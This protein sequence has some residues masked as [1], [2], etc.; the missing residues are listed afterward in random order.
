MNVLDRAVPALRKAIRTVWAVLW[1]AVKKYDE[2]DAEQRAASFAYYAFFALF[3]LIVLLISV[4]TT[5]LGSKER[6]TTEITRYVSHYMPTIEEDDSSRIVGTIDGVVKS[7]Q[8]AGLIAFGILA[9]TAM[10]FFHALVRGVNRAWGT[11]EY[12]WWRLPI[13]N[14][15]MTA[16]LAS[17]LLVGILAPLVV[18]QVET[19]YWAHS[20]ELGLNFWFAENFFN[21]LRFLV[22]PLVLFYGFFMLYKVSPRRKTTFR[23]V[24]FSALFV[25]VGVDVLQR[26]FTI[27]TRNITNFNALYGTFGGVVALLFWIYLIGSIIIFGA[28]LSAAQYE[29]KMSLADQSE[30]A[31]AK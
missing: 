21:L 17:A 27:Y 28:C 22:P 30:S 12:V 18:R 26:L 25:T 10:R 24:W 1:R 20:W 13:K 14:L 11:K 15:A 6:A 16:I 8:S 5:F 4:S 2:T 29:V 31:Y 9:W 19:F 3:P 7:R 23:E